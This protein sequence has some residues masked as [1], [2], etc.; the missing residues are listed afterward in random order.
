VLDALTKNGMTVEP[1]AGT[2]RMRISVPADGSASESDAMAKAADRVREVVPAHGY[3]IS[4]PVRMHDA[5]GNGNG[6][7]SGGVREPGS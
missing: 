4:E 1:V 5:G 2:A 3:F 7:G 6:S